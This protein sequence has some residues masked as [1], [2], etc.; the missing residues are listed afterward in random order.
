M[1]GESVLRPHWSK[2][3]NHLSTPAM[4][5]WNIR[6]FDFCTVTTGLFIQVFGWTDSTLTLL[7]LWGTLD[8]PLFFFPSALLLRKSLRL[9]V[10]TRPDFFLPPESRFLAPFAWWWGRPSDV[11]L[12]Y[13]QPLSPPSQPAVMR[14]QIPNKCLMFLFRIHYQRYRRSNCHGSPNTD[15]SSLVSSP[16]KSSSILS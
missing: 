15:I 12:Y 14:V 3:L 9:S 13:F 5:Q 6:Q 10:V 2:S 8:F 1:G 4:C 16:C 11:F 7:T